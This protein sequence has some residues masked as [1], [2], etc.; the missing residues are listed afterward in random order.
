[1]FDKFG[2][3]VFVIGPLLASNLGMQQYSSLANFGKHN[4]HYSCLNLF[5]DQDETQITLC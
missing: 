1:M 4:I 3:A 5:S 2:V